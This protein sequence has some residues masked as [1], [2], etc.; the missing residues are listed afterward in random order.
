MYIL[1]RLVVSQENRPLLGWK[2]GRFWQGEPPTFPKERNK[3][4]KYETFYTL[5]FTLWTYIHYQNTNVHHQN[6]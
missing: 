3:L 2:S 5:K 6:T 4:H 1:S